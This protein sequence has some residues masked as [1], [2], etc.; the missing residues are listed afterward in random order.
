M[1]KR[2]IKIRTARP[3]DDQSVTALI[4]NCHTISFAPF[5]SSDW[6]GSRDLPEHQSKWQKILVDESLSA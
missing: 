5:A 6:V 4:S 2:P 3:E 1:Q